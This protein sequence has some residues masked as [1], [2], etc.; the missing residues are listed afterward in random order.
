MND[1]DREQS[2]PD[3]Q[4]RLV[5]LLEAAHTD[6]L[7]AEQIIAACAEGGF[8]S[9]GLAESEASEAVRALKYAPSLPPS[10]DA[11]TPAIPPDDLKILHRLATS[12][13]QR[14][15]T[16]AALATDSDDRLACLQ[17][18]LHAGRLS[19]ALL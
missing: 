11:R 7:T 13:T 17:A 19:D 12:A 4:A 14:L 18:A 1:R 6:L 15:I 8:I 2:A 16:A 3:D 9:W 10:V 5:S